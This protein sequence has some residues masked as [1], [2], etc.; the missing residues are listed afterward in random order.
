MLCGASLPG[1]P[2]RPAGKTVCQE[3]QG[4]EKRALGL[5]WRLD[6]TVSRQILALSVRPK[7]DM[8]K[9]GLMI[10]TSEQEK[11]GAHLAAC[12]G[13]TAACAPVSSLPDQTMARV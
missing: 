12:A 4:I 1:V 6:M 3:I 2:L 13:R 8:A 9:P 11:A 10:S 5:L 7:A